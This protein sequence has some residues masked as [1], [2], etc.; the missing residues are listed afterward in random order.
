MET[1][2]VTTAI[3]LTLGLAAYL[4]YLWTGLERR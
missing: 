3:V 1:A 4:V 2:L